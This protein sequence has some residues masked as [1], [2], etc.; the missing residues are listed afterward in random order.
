M[1]QCSGNVREL[2]NTIERSVV[3]S[4]TQ[5]I[6]RDH[7]PGLNTGQMEET[8]SLRIPIGTRIDELSGSH[9]ANFN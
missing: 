6:D 1:H 4:T 7:L 8:Q 5:L 3:P 2:E 9:S